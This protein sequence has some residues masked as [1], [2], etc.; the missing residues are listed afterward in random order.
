MLLGHLSLLFSVIG[1]TKKTHKFNKWTTIHMILC[2]VQFYTLPLL[3]R[4]P[5]LSLC[6]S[7]SLSP[8]GPLSFNKSVKCLQK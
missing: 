4:S 1:H 2:C 7:L 6:P 5:S 3:T 8:G